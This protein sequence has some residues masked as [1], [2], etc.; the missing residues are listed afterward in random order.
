[1][2]IIATEVSER[3]IER[4]PQ[5]KANMG[6]QIMIYEERNAVEPPE[7][8]ILIPPPERSLQAAAS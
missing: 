3:R 7:G 6:T 8:R 5:R 1:V 2:R 4:S